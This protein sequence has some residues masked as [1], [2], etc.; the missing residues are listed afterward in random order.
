[1]LL[2]EAANEAGQW[3]GDGYKKP[4]EGREDQTGDGDSVKRDGHS[5]GLIEV[6]VK[7]T[8][9]RDEFYATDHDGCKQESRDGKSTST[10]MRSTSMVRA[11]R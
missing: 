4:E 6:H 11:M 3:C 7:S 1:M 10:L 8:D 9:V 2:N 5:V